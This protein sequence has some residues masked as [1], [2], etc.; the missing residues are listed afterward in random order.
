MLAW[1]KCFQTNRSQLVNLNDSNSP[2]SPVTSGFPL[3]SVL[4]PLLFLIYIAD[5]PVCVSSSLSIFADDCAIYR[6]IVNDPD[7]L[8][9]YLNVASDWCRQWHMT[10]NINKCKI[11]KFSSHK[12][13][14]STYYI[15]EIPLLC[16]TSYKYL[17]MYIASNLSWHIDNILCKDNSMLHKT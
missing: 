1:I 4:E 15:S 14:L 7:V 16:A 13:F 2:V 12:T 5:I 17:G 10:L 6:K 11:I 8:Q 3:D 9:N